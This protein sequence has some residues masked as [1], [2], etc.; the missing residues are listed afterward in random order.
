MGVS[1]YCNFRIHPRLWAAILLTIGLIGRPVQADDLFIARVSMSKQLENGYNIIA[2]GGDVYESY[3]GK[4]G[5]LGIAGKAGARSNWELG[6]FAYYPQVKSGGH[7]RDDRLRGSLS[8]QFSIN[9]W[10]LSHRS[11]IEYRKGEITKGFRYRPAFELSRA[12]SFETTKIIPY[13]E[14]EPI[15]D[16]RK[17]KVTTVFFTAGVKWPISSRVVI[18]AGHFNIF[19]RDNSKHTKGPVLG[20]HLLL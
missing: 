13:T 10:Q 4:L 15:Y 8:Y 9:N 19:T 18:N 20:L 1:K 14:I 7:L 12:L 2:A 5:Y 17:E 6:Y 11:R 16:L 3:K